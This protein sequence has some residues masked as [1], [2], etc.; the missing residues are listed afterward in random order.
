MNYDQTIDYLLSL[1]KFG[2]KFG[3]SSTEN[4]LSRLGNPHLAVPAVHLAG[5]NGKGSVGAM[6][7][8][9]TAAS[10]LRVG[11]YT[12]PHLISF[13]ER[14]R[15]NG[16]LIEPGDVVSLAERVK[17]VSAPEEPPT[18]F[19]FVTAMGFLYF[20][21]KK[22]DLLVLETG[23]GGRLDATNVVLPLAGV[24]TNI[25]MEHTDYL[26]KTLARI[27][28]EKAGIIKPGLAVVTGEKRKSV[29]AI[30]EETAEARGGRILALGRDFKVIKRGFGLFDYY[31]LGRKM[32]R[33]EVNLIGDH[34]I[35]N[36][37]LALAVMELLADKGFALDEGIIR[38]GLAEASWPGRAQIFPGPPRLMLD[39]A[40]NPHAAK[41][42]ARLLAG[43]EYE[44]LHLV[45]GIMADK[46]IRAVMAPLLPL[47]DVLYLT[48]TA[49]SRGAAP[50]VLAEAARSFSGNKEL[51]PSIPDALA[52]A[53][54]AAG[55]DDLVVATG[56][57][58]TV[59][60][61]L[62]HLTGGSS[63]Q[64]G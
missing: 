28:A 29:R 14:F 56:S 31:G 3:L 32:A 44:R 42:L 4:L 49:Y 53:L 17:A 45:L 54:A 5:T 47:A 25:S 62:A 33:L 60:E 59:G 52:A 19:E 36:A 63:R 2:I 6:I 41:T 35:R 26:G 11:F 51:H 8:S 23:M 38:K 55:R 7:A 46:D 10:G 40:H 58:F 48:R 12:S 20:A 22:V 34:Q 61:A 15:I 9:M 50:E 18:F 21:E 24:I 64:E 13:R 30:F 16:E 57:L 43:L 39:G 1:Q 37:G 27:A